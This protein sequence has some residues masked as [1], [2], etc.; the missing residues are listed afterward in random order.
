MQAKLR[1]NPAPL[2]HLRFRSNHDTRYTGN[3][4]SDIDG[5]R[6]YVYNA[7]GCLVEVKT[8]SS[9]LATYAYNAL[10]Q[11]VQKDDQVQETE[12]VYDLEGN[13]IGEYA[14]GTPLREY[15]YLNGVPVLQIESA[16]KGR[17][18]HSGISSNSF[19]I[20]PESRSS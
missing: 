2:D 11:R 17:R 20:Q 8:G 15:V 12:F 6:I 4:I 5:A 18:I 3:R 7:A 10:G 16:T 9:T 1:R 19:W 14:D 13:L